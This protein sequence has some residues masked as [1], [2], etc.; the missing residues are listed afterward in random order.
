[1]YHDAKTVFYSANRFKFS[2]PRPL[3]PFIRRLDDVSHRNLAVR[4][5]HLYVRVCSKNEE[6][7]WDNT[8]GRLRA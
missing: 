6:R 3:N 7:E 1:M 5:V 8:F 4:S 2:N